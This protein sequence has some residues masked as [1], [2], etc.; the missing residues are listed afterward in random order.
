MT[1]HSKQLNP[2]LRSIL[3]ITEGVMSIITPKERAVTTWDVYQAAQAQLN[4]LGTSNDYG[5]VVPLGYVKDVYIDSGNNTFCLYTKGDGKLYTMTVT[6]DDQSQITFGPET[7]V[8]MEFT[9]VSRS[10][11]RVQRSADGTARWFAA[12]ACT[13]VLNRS[14]EIDST[15]LFDSFVEYIERTGEYPSM[16]FFHLDERLTFGVAD[17]VFR[18]GVNLVI[19]GTFDGSDFANA[20]IE[21]IERDG[22]YWGLSI[23]YLP[24]EYPENIRSQEGIEIPVFNAGILRFVSLLPEDT[25]ASILTSISVEEG[26]NRMNAIQEKALRELTGDNVVLFEQ[27]KEQLKNNNRQADE[28]GVI[29]RKK[30]SVLAVKN[31]AKPVAAKPVA[32]PATPATETPVVEREISD[33]DIEALFSSEKFQT[34]F[35][36]FIEARATAAANDDDAEEGEEAAEE[37]VAAATEEARAIAALSKNVTDLTKIVTELQKERQVEQEIEDDLPEKLIQARIRRPRGSSATILPSHLRNEDRQ[38]ISLAEVA[39]RTLSNVGAD[40]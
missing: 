14:G 30:Q 28:P 40:K 36:E 35:G 22:D 5:D 37:P 8:F 21:A 2:L 6:V 13:A 10:A 19:S 38:S 12:P 9:P 29:T 17:L 18:D 25:A 39:N 27:M 31:S 20:A 34:K 1:T 23:A 11:I 7:E 15:K 24:T 4:D 26:V 16:D 32:T 3:K 33:D